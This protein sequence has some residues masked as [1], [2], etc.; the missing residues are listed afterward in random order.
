MQT[1]VFHILAKKKI[2]SIK[3]ETRLVGMDYGVSEDPSSD[4][5]TSNITGEICLKTN[6]LKAEV[7]RT[8][9]TRNA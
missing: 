1:N 6:H 4:P 3:T 2:K 5:A 9:E 7:K 8:E